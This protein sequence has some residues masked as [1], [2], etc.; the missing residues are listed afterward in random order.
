MSLH[1]RSGVAFDMDQAD[2]IPEL[3]GDDEGG[4]TGAVRPLGRP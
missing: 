1:R 3:L 2:M 4:F